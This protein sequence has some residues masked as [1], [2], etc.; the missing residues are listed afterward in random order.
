M[1]T[2]AR[3]NLELVERDEFAYGVEFLEAEVGWSLD[4]TSW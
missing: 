2:R 1:T 4:P 3:R